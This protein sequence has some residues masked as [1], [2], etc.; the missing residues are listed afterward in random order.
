[1]EMLKLGEACAFRRRAPET[2]ET[3]ETPAACTRR[4]ARAS[5]S[6][7]EMRDATAS[8][9]NLK[10][11]QAACVC[12]CVCTMTRKVKDRRKIRQTQP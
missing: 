5:I 8:I 10:Q 6:M 4:A 12:P 11:Q 1:M 3:P 2:P 9:S 7:P